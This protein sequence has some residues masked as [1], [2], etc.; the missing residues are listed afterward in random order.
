MHLKGGSFGRG[1]PRHHNAKPH[2]LCKA[3]ETAGSAALPATTG[4]SPA[5]PCELL[6]L[7]L[8]AAAYEGQQQEAAEQP[9]AAGF[10]A[11][12]V[13]AVVQT[14]VQQACNQVGQDA[15]QR[16]LG[17]DESPLQLRCIGF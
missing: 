8:Q 16:L 9:Q 13:H 10:L 1:V 17:P 2:V 4:C 7:L 3:Q 11:D 15:E 5:L 6:L 12:V 14:S